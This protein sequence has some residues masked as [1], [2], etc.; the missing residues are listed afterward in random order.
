MSLYR[1]LTEGALNADLGKNSLKIFN[2]LLTQTLGYGKPADR[3]TDKRLSQLSTVRLDRFRLSVHTVLEA[4]L[5]DRQPSKKFQWQYSIGAKYLEAH[6]A[7]FAEKNPEASANG[8]KAP[9]FPPFLPKNSTD[10]PKKEPISGKQSHTALDLESFLSYLPPLLQ[11]LTPATLSQNVPAMAGGASMPTAPDAELSRVIDKSIQSL[12]DILKQGLSELKNSINPLLNPHLSENRSQA[13]NS[14]LSAYT[15]FSSGAAAKPLGQ[16]GGGCGGYN[17]SKVASTPCATP[18]NKEH[19]TQQA[20]LSSSPSEQASENPPVSTENQKIVPP[21]SEVQ[22]DPH[23]PLAIELPPSLL[24]YAPNLHKALL[25]LDEHQQKQVLYVFKHMESQGEI[26]KSPS[27]LFIHLAKSALSGTLNLPEAPIHPAVAKAKA[28]ARSDRF[29]PEGHPYADDPAIQWGY[30]PISQPLD[31]SSTPYEENNP[32]PYYPEEQEEID[33]IVYEQRQADKEA[34][35]RYRANQ[36]AQQ[37]KKEEQAKAARCE[38]RSQAEHQKSAAT[39][40]QILFAFLELGGQ[41]YESLLKEKDFGYLE[42]IY[43]DEIAAHRKDLSQ[44]RAARRNG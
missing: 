17:F 25:P 33:E 26:K 10:S 8:E 32:Y 38:P 2:T 13:Y 39:D 21:A 12:A 6:Q 18:P 11:L 29:K 37:R 34:A 35:E 27:G 3:L 43:A 30:S 9:F 19:S 23:Y 24:N 22:D 44:R 36:A 15:P 41:T 42:D 7:A 1:D 28:K 31:T 14:P 5:F 40:L 20:S 4:G 16:V